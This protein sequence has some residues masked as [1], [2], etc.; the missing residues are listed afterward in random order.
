[1]NSEDIHP[2]WVVHLE[3]PPIEHGLWLSWAGL[4]RLQ[5]LI[6]ELRAAPDVTFSAE[7]LESLAEFLSQAGEAHSSPDPE[8]HPPRPFR[9][10]RLAHAANELHARAESLKESLTQPEESS[11]LSPQQ[12]KTRQDFI[13]AWA[14]VHQLMSVGGG[15]SAPLRG[16]TGIVELSLVWGW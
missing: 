13:S 10:E 2:K 15:P 9:A 6:L 12:M 16:C 5:E 8:A 4:A 7:T 1:M 11:A 14:S 3:G